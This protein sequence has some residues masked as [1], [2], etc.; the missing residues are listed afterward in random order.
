MHVIFF[1]R[2][3]PG[4]RFLDLD[5]ESLF[6]RTLVAWNHVVADFR[7]FSTCAGIL[8]SA[9]YNGFD[10]VIQIFLIFMH[11]VESARDFGMAC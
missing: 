8:L 11:L 5:C 2:I 7:S 1:L 4:W 9:H 3:K 10:Q 6:G